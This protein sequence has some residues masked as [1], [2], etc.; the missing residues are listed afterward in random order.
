VNPLQGGWVILLT[1]G[2]AMVLAIVHL[3]ETWPQWLGWLRPAWVALVIF[4]W[5][6]ELPHRIGLISAWVVGCL[7]DVLLGEPLG[8]NGALLAAITYVAWRFYER[9]RMYSVI[10]QAGVVFLLVL[11]TEFL[12]AVVMQLAGDRPFSWGLAGP[13]LVSLVVWP[14]LATL[15]DAV[16]RRMRV[17]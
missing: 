10:Q 7:V 17:Q 9:L 15:L 8:L 5:V 4:Y 6:M 3:P 2:G 1:L 11:G 16:R 12:R 14:F 13:A